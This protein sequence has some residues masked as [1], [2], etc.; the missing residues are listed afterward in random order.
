M[1]SGRGEAVEKYREVTIM[2]TLYKVYT[3]VLA[4]RLREEMEGKGVISQN[5]TRFRKGMGMLDNIYVMNYLVNRQV[6]RKGGKVVG[7]LLIIYL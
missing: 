3:A 1:K 7:Y 4:E 6:G 5:Q 2:P